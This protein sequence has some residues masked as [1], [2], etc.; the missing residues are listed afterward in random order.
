[1]RISATHV[2]GAL[3]WLALQHCALASP[4]CINPDAKNFVLA[5]AKGNLADGWNGQW[6]LQNID[7]HDRILLRRCSDRPEDSCYFATDVKPGRYYFEEVVPLGKNDLQ[8]P[9]STPH[10]WFTI[11]GMGVDYIGRWLIE[12]PD[13]R[14]VTK[15]DI[16]YELPDLDKMLALCEIK[17]RKLYLDRTR[18]PANQIVD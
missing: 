11:T 8:Y 2:T 6:L 15:L 16:H 4:V 12:R 18:M 9:V 13:R 1:M 5:S 10:L 17:D 14:V 7:S 3:I